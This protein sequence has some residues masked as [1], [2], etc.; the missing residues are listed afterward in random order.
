MFTYLL[1]PSGSL[2]SALPS[3]KIA[4]DTR[5]GMARRR[6]ARVAPVDQRAHA[7]ASIWDVDAGFL[8]VA[9]CNMPLPHCPLLWE[10]NAAAAVKLAV[11]RANCAW[12]KKERSEGERTKG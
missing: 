9:S 11:A 1:S 6:G 5:G 3:R 10:I 8:Q 4:Q 2:C 12:R 7:L